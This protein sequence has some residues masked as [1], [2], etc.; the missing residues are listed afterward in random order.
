MP[1][2]GF[3]DLLDMEASGPVNDQQRVALARIKANQQHLLVL[4][5]EILSFARVETRPHGVSQHRRTDDASAHRRGGDAE[6]GDRRQRA[7]SSTVQVAM[8]GP[9]P[10]PI[11]IASAKSS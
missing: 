11:P 3:V 5:T 9:S 2:R 1:L 6:R 7:H 4:I 10:G 8:V